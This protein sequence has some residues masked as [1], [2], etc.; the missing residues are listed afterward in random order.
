MV[1][2]YSTALDFVLNES[3]FEASILALIWALFLAI[4]YFRQISS[5][6][7]KMK[8]SEPSSLKSHHPL[9]F[10]V[11]NQSD[12]PQKVVLLGFNRNFQKQNFGSDPQV[13]VQ[14][15]VST[16]SYIEMVSD[17]AMYPRDL[18]KIRM[19]HDGNTEFPKNMIFHSAEGI[20]RKVSQS[21]NLP[22][23]ESKLDKSGRV[24]KS[25]I[26]F[27]QKWYVDSR[28]FIEF[29]APPNSVFNIALFFTYR[30]DDATQFSYYEP[31]KEYNERLQEKA[32]ANWN[33]NKEL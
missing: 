20:G 33:S 15:G 26:D 19:S 21:R 25:I 22:N 28:S 31:N 6:Q 8:E 12:F 1:S 13:L 9:V 11:K 5:P 4:H 17:C 29:T 18:H 32:R 7:N 3:F 16:I 2:D 30:G 23:I 27:Y 14:S 24:Q 10:S